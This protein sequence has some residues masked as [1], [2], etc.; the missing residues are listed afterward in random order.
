MSI[1]RSLSISVV[2]V[3]SSVGGAS[4]LLGPWCLLCG[5]VDPG[6]S[7]FL[8]AVC[9]VRFLDHPRD[10]KRT[11]A[12]IQN[13]DDDMMLMTW[14]TSDTAERHLRQRSRNRI[15]RNTTKQKAR[16]VKS[17]SSEEAVNNRKAYQSIGNAFGRGDTIPSLFA[18]K[19]LPML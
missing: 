13:V 11:A 2:V 19:L 7:S 14:K 17:L 5:C 3:F 9:C 15:A 10:G 18:E 6:S 1:Q 16:M 12:K 8:C 4:C